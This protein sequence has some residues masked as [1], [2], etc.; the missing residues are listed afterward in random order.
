MTF[1]KVPLH[2]IKPYNNNVKQHPVKQLEELERNIRKF[3]FRG[4]IL[5][6]KN[7]VIIA[8]HARY[9][10]ATALGYPDIMCEYADDLTPEQVAEYRV[11]DNMI[12]SM[13]YTDFA[14]LEVE[15]ALMPDADF[16]AFDL[17]FPDAPIE[18]DRLSD[19][20]ENKTDNEI[21]ITCPECEHR[22]VYNKDK[23]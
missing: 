12:A 1:R 8:G 22:F 2:E 19:E 15:M 13:G 9:E 10:A 4:S 7:N 23:G 18:P 5:L 17:K 16:S 3:G 21:L 20:D 14:K 11:K 6:D